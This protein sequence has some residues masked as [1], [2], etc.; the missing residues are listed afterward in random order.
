MTRTIVPLTAIALLVP[1]VA[2]ACPVCFGASDGPILQGSNMGIL[3][4][5]LVTVAMLGIF[6]GFF[7]TLARRAGRP[8]P[9][10]PPPLDIT[11]QPEGGAR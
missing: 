2:A 7:I 5:L 3:A 9:E 11:R 4:L 1:R 6:G 10:A 8:L